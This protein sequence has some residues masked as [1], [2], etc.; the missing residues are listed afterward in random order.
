[1]EA[2]NDNKVKTSTS[3]VSVKDSD[4]VADIGGMPSLIEVIMSRYC[5][6]LIVESFLTESVFTNFVL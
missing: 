1:V 6:L 2:D 4:L 3:S 5:M